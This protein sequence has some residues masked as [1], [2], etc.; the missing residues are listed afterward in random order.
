MSCVPSCAHLMTDWKIDRFFISICKVF[1]IGGYVSSKENVSSTLLRYSIC[2]WIGTWSGTLIHMYILVLLRSGS[3]EI[4]PRATGLPLINVVVAKDANAL[5]IHYPAT[6]VFKSQQ[7]L[8]S[9]SPPPRTNR[10]YRTLVRL[11]A[12]LN[13]FSSKAKLKCIYPSSTCVSLLTPS[14]NPA[15]MPGISSSATW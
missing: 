5:Q 13:T 12:P 1:L 11:K 2:S 7:R 14:R 3:N 10:L 15:E 8:T 4:P 6:S 9:Q